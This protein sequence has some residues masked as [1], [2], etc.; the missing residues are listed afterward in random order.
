MPDQFPVINGTLEQ[1][2]APDAAI[3]FL[4]L[5]H[6]LQRHRDVWIVVPEKPFLAVDAGRVQAH[7]QGLEAFPCHRPP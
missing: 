3:A 1:P 5:E 4:R 6:V 2:T 7:L